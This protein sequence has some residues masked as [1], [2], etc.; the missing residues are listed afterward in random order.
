MFG[1]DPLR[2]LRSA[3]EALRREVLPDVPDARAEEAFAD[4][5]RLVELLE[6]E[7]LR[8]LADIERRGL[9][10]RDGHLSA[11]AWLVHQFRVS[12]AAPG[13]RPVLRARWRECRQQGR[14]PRPER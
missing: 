11:A 4:L 6:V 8:R 1:D 13:R 5:H 7:R 9:F 3:L 10:V 12:W 14:R 2:Q